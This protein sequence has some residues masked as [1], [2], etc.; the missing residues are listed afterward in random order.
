MKDVLARAALWAAFL[1]LLLAFTAVAITPSAR[2]GAPAGETPHALVVLLVRTDDEKTRIWEAVTD[3]AA[4]I[5]SETSPTSS[6]N[7]TAEAMTRMPHWLSDHRP[8]WDLREWRCLPVDEVEAF[9]KRHRGA[10]I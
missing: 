10:E 3:L 7:C 6:M 2:A 1:Y 9:L 5:D 8:G 4:P